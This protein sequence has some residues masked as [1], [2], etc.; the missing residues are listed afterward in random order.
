LRFKEE[1]GVVMPHEYKIILIE[2]MNMLFK[3]ML[4]ESKDDIALKEI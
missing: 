3:G 2:Y 4:M 1:K